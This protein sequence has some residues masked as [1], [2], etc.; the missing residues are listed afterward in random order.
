MDKKKSIIFLIIGYIGVFIALLFLRLLLMF[1]SPMPVLVR[2][3]FLIITYIPLATAP[4]ILSLIIKDTPKAYGFTKEKLPLQII[5]GIVFGLTL[6]FFLTLSFYL[7]GKREWVG[8]GYKYTELWQFI[9]EF[10]Y[11]VCAV[12]FT[13]EIIF[14]GFMYKRCEEIFAFNNIKNPTLIKDLGAIALSSLLFGFFHILNGNIVQVFSTAFIGVLFCLMRKVKNCSTLSLILAHGIYDA[15]I[16]VW[17]SI[18]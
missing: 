11:A 16:V 18:L 6:S 17:A 2:M 8:P 10:I 7:F 1:I 3:P 9:Y 4:I 5:W 14:R 12:G 13:E 15:L